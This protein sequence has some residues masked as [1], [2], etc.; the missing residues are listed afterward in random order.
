MKRVK[1][2]TLK[3]F[4]LTKL[5]E[6]QDIF[7]KHYCSQNIQY[8]Y[9]ELRIIYFLKKGQVHYIYFMFEKTFLQGGVTLLDFWAAFIRNFVKNISK[10]I[11]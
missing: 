1:G 8:S 4:P 2:L 3:R 5:F 6:K 7:V 10:K 11:Q 9:M